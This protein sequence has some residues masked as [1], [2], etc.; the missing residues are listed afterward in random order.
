MS[1][2]LAETIVKRF[3][4]ISISWL[5]TGVGEMFVSELDTAH[6]ISYYNLDVE[7]SIRVVTSIEPESKMVLPSDIDADFAMVY[8]G[9]AMGSSIPTNTIV[10]LKQILSEQVIFGKE[11]L[12]TTPTLSSLRVVRRAEGGND[13]L[14]LVAIATDKYDDLIVRVEDIDAIYQV[15]AKLIVNY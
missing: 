10:I 11:Y 9:D 1:R 5:L 15:A 13:A 12:V 6:K 14:R 7:S 2:K 4:E 8:R 3:P